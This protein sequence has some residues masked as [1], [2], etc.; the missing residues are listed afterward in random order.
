MFL[1][2]KIIAPFF[3]PVPLIF[4]LSLAGLFLL[5]FTSKQKIG[6]IFITAGFSVFILCSFSLTSDILI[7]PLESRY[8]PVS[9]ETLLSGAEQLPEMVVVLSG[10]HTSNTAF[11]M[12]SQIGQDSL[13][14]LIE[15]I[16]I[17]R[18]IPGCK[19][20]LSG[21]SVYGPVPAAEAMA[22]VAR[23]IGVDEEDIIIEAES[24]DTDDQARIIKSM[25]GD[26]HFI[27][28]T[29]ASHMPRSIALFRKL[30]M[31]PLPAPT[32]HKVIET[33]YW[34]AGQFFPSS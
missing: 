16:R 29:S 27:L 10:G 22:R 8:P 5:W 6:K 34:T 9:D 13:T 33:E 31:D 19:L 11:P 30:G 4:F 3:F 15:G 7:R 17:Y 24:R 32:M 12:T 1:L 26:R 23:S 28:V 18:R 2:K 25:L 20:L 21:G 14:R